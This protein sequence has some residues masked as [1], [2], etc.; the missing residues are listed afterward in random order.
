MA[1]SAA[2][3]IL[4]DLPV[5]PSLR[6]ARFSERNLR[7]G[8]GQWAGRPFVLEPWQYDEVVVPIYDDLEPS[9]LRRVREALIGVAKKNGKT[10]LGA[11]FGAYGLLADGHYVR[12]PNGWLW[13]RELGAEVYNV[14][15][16]RQQA[17]I[18]FE[19]ASSFIL[20]SPF[21]PPVTK[22]YRDAIEVP[23]T[24]SVWRVLAADAKL[25]H[26]PNP[27]TAIIDEIWVHRSPELYEAFASAGAAR[28][29]PLLVVIT[30]AGFDQESVAFQLYRNGLGRHSRRFY[31]RWW[32]APDG[33]R[34]DD[35][36][37]FRK[38]NPSQWITA[39]YLR[40]ELARARKVGLENQFRRFH[41]NQWTTVSEAAIPLELW[42]TCADRP[43][44]PDGAE[45][46][47][48][49]DLAPLHDSSAVVIDH[50]DGAGVHNVRAWIMHADPDTGYL[51][52]EALEQLVRELCRRYQVRVIYTDPAYAIRSMVMLQEEGLPVETFPQ[53]DAR[54]VPASLNLYELLITERVRH[55]G[56]RALRRQVQAAGKKATARGWRLHKLKSTGLIDAVVATAMA[57][58]GWEQPEE[59]EPYPTLFV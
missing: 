28:Q 2:A 55:G 40:D 12:D 4:L 15:G 16:S 23:E 17:K 43:R 53:S 54:M 29:Q 32:Q 31:F 20:R 58:F 46:I 41:G 26:G 27:S 47:V 22:L 59:E 10:H 24:E 35:M 30:T 11:L 48:A 50:R 8:K 21:R 57:A 6:V 25:A 5:R 3:P 33:C 34:L 19:I 1:R 14:A 45:V 42:D 52:F 49:V 9:G 37:A 36:R 7:H 38:A 56:N 44:I 39:A 51:D 13:V 18:L